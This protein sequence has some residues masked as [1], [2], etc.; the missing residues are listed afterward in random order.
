M[1]PK[2]KE[3]IVYSRRPKDQ[4]EIENCTHPQYCQET[5]S[6]P[7]HYTGN[8]SSTFDCPNDLDLPIAL[9]KEKRTCTSYPIGNFLSYDNLSSGYKAFASSLNDIQI[10]RNVQEA[11][12]QPRWKEAVV[13]E[14]NAL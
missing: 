14:M 5:S 8:N 11:L 4:K 9:R 2:E 13:E 12:E 10:P 3:L 6:S 7:Q 1:N